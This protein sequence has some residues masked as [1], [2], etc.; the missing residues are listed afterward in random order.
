MKFSGSKRDIFIVFMKR[1]KII[2]VRE[3]L[4]RSFRE[5]KFLKEILSL[6]ELRFRFL[7]EPIWWRR[8]M[9]MIAMAARTNGRM[10]WMEKKRLRVGFS[11][12]N[13]PH[14]QKV[15][16]S[17]MIGTVDR[18]FV[19]TVA[20]HKDI[21]PHGST[22]PMNAVAIRIIKIENPDAHVWV[23]LNELFIRLRK[24]WRKI[25]AKKV[26]A[27]VEW[28]NLSMNPCSRLRE[29]SM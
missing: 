2:R 3:N 24:M 25:R 13:L 11:T 22:Y 19:I 28:E 15:S 5:K 21:W 12:L 29:T 26:D 16:F 14:S 1:M 9:W 10:K 18:R 8:D 23:F 27:P 17:P 6:L 20:P 4:V 7:D